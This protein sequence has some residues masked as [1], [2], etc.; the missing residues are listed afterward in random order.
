MKKQKQDV[1]SYDRQRNLLLLLVVGLLF[2][3]LLLFILYASSVA[4]LSEEL[5]KLIGTIWGQVTLVDLYI[6]LI[7]SAFWVYYREKYPVVAIIWAIVFF[8]TGFLS[9]SFYIIIQLSFLLVHQ[10][11]VRFFMGYR[12]PEVD[13]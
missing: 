7:L 6:G 3:I 1:R 8:L 10:N 13:R 5:G 9:V 11:P 12:T 4:S 2:C